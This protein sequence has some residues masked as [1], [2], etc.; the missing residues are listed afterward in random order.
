MAKVLES[1][2]PV[3]PPVPVAVVSMAKVLESPNPV[4]PLSAKRHEH[5]NMLSKTSKAVLK[6]NIM[7]AS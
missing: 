3:S 2:N 1:P 5:T 6:R 4:S 7:L